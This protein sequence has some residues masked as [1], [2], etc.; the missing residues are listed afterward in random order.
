MTSTLKPGALDGIKVLDLSRVLAG[1]WAGQ[2]LADLGADVVKV[3]RPG[4][5]DDTRAWGPPWLK[6]AE[7]RDTRDAAYFFCANRNKRS[8]AIDIATPEGQA[9]V[10]QLAA[11]AD[12][13]LENFK[14]GGLKQYGL[15][16]D[17]LKTVNPRLIYCSITGFGQDGPYAQRPGYDFLIQGMGGL[18][19][20]TGP[21][22]VPRADG[23]SAPEGQGPQKVGVALVD[24]MTG[25]YASIG[26]LAALQHRH[27]TG[28][29]Q[30]IDLALLDVQVAA[31]ANQTANYLIGGRVPRRMGN[32][33]PNIVPYQD[34]PTADGDMIV[35]VGNDG[36]FARLAESAGHPEWAADERFATNAARVANRATLIPLLRQATVMRTTREWIERLEA[37]G[38]PC[39]PINRL[40]EVF[41]DPQVVARGLRVELPHPVAGSVPGVANPIRLSASPV[42]YRTAPPTLGQHTA[43]V[44]ADWL[45]A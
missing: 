8:V 22:E 40:D 42:A 24:I 35:A 6:D 20:V 39:G 4:A 9:L 2:M 38:V 3:E 30:H 10:R 34:F 15:D 11:Q 44:L 26:V 7:G 31:L 13:L 1:P 36:Q 29:G 19:S 43:E 23:E 21:A 16:Y 33:H 14:V 17:S 25:L 12:V 32:A 45:G 18:M 28:E 37:A 5:G 41:A 27:A